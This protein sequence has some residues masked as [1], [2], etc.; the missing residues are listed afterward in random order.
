MSRNTPRTSYFSLNDAYIPWVTNKSWLMQESSC[1]KLEWFV[2]IWWFVVKESNIS[3]YTQVQIF[4]H[5]SEEVG[6]ASSLLEIVCHFLWSVTTFDFFHSS[7]KIPLSKHHL[8]II[9][10]GLHNNDAHT[11]NIRMLILSWSCAFSESKFGLFSW[12]YR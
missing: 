1:L 2:E 9:S 3:L 4:F 12:C 11:C 8:K 5:I 7:G 10:R 6:L